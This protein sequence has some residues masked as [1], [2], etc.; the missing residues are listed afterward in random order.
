MNSRI[1]G[2]RV[3]SELKTK[4]VRRLLTSG[5]SQS[6]S[7]K[8]LGVSNVSLFKRMRRAIRKIDKPNLNLKDPRIGCN[9]L[10]A[11]NFRLKQENETLRQQREI[12]RKSIGLRSSDPL[13]KGMA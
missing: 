8:Q 6:Q 4:A 1:K 7:G 3:T 13:Q 9:V 12:F 5:K 11:E 10:E 2:K